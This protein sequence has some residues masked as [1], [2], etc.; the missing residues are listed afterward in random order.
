MFGWG[1]KEFQSPLHRVKWCNPCPGAG[2]RA[3]VSSF[4]PL[5]IGSSGA[6]LLEL[7]C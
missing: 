1:P 4:S 2:C 5:F 3:W 7:Q 6:T